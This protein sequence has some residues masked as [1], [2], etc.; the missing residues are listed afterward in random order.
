[1]NE[2]IPTLHR[3]IGEADSNPTGS[4]R[5]EALMK[6]RDLMTANVSC[7]RSSES[8]SVAARVMW[9][10]DC[11]AIPVVDDERGKYVVGMLT[12]RD[13]CMAAWSKDQPLSAIPVRE[14]MASSVIGCSPDDNLTDVEALMQTKQLRRIPVVDEENELFGILSLADIARSAAAPFARGEKPAPSEIAS[15]LGRIVQPR[16]QPQA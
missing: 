6:V 7:V 1:M 3:A 14:A 5:K 4:Y 11:G 13:I 8:L 2:A 12:D 16:A 10:R 15:T 9:D